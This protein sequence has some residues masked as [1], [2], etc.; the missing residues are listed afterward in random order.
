MGRH[1]LRFTTPNLGSSL[2]ISPTELSSDLDPVLPFPVISGAV[3]IPA[4]PV[5]NVGAV[6]Q[7][8]TTAGSAYNSLQLGLR[9][10][11]I[12]SKLNFQ[13]YYT[14]S[15]A[16]DD[17]SDVFDLAGAYVLPQDSFNLSAE[18]G[19]ANFDRRHSF[20]YSFSLEVPA[21]DR[22]LLLRLLARN[23]QVAGTGRVASGQPFTVNST[24]DVNLDGNL[25]DRLN[26][27]NGLQITG[28]GQTP[29]RL[30]TANLLG[31]LASFGQ[32]GRIGRNSFTAGGLVDLDLAVTK[33]FVFGSR[34]LRFRT[35]LFNFPNRTNFGIPVRQLEA[36]GFGNATKTITPGRRIQFVIKYEF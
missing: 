16:V 8:E 32:D 7:F 25:T 14:F 6:N 4:R 10:R 21:S 11:F 35:E 28:I 18:R 13:A 30:T 19:P 12:R 26:A 36:T 20:V 22:N 17:V 9:E 24:I 3:Q 15:K 2:T 27:T 1:L 33:G 29:L 23:V 34:S 5:A 31:M